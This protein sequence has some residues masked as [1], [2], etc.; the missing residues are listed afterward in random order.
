[1]KSTPSSSSSSSLKCVL[2]DSITRLILQ[3]MKNSEI[4]EEDRILLLNESSSTFFLSV[5][6]L[7]FDFYSE[8]DLVLLSYGCGVSFRLDDN[9]KYISSILPNK[10]KKVLNIEFNNELSIVYPCQL[11]YK[12]GFVQDAIKY[13]KKSIKDKKYSFPRVLKDKKKKSLEN[14]A[15]YEKF[16]DYKGDLKAHWD[17]DGIC[18]LIPQKMK[19]PFKSNLTIS[20]HLNKSQRVYTKNFYIGDKSVRN[21][22]S[23]KIGFLKTHLGNISLYIIFHQDYVLDFSSFIQNISNIL[24]VIS[25]DNETLEYTL[26]S[27]DLP[28]FIQKIRF[29]YPLSSFFI[30]SYGS[31]NTLSNSNFF[32]V[33][34]T[35]SSIFDLSLIP[36]L[37]YDIAVT[38]NP[39]SDSLIILKEKIFHRLRLR[40]IYKLA[41]SIK[42]QNY[43]ET[44]I[45]RNQIH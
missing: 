27:N 26:A 29:L 35:L 15:N 9:I 32:S 23:V 2:I 20:I 16:F 11:E 44:K 36:T 8:I 37:I 5:P 30:E 13:I 25:I 39:D 21:I 10:F 34:N 31:K 14:Y 6:C 4:F 42:M 38:V 12:E 28:N 22:P 24:D 33:Y 3:N 19:S 40:T 45:T 1:M 43:N 17:I 7:E 18:G 41:L